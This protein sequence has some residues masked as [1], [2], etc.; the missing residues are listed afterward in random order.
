MLKNDRLG[1]RTWRLLSLLACATA[2]FAGC[3]GPESSDSSEPTTVSQSHGVVSDGLVISQVYGGGGN[4]VDGGS[5]SYAQDFVELFNRS[6]APIP[7]DGLS[8]QY[9]SV[10]GLLGSVNTNIVALPNK[11]VPAGGYFLVALDGPD[12]G[13]GA[14]ALPT[15]DAT[16]LA[17]LS[18]SSGKVALARTTTA[19]RCGG[20]ADGGTVPCDAEKIVDL[21]GY[22]TANYAEGN[23]VSGTPGALNAVRRRDAGCTETDSNA[24]DFE[25]VSPTPRNAATTVNV[26]A[27]DGGAPDAEVDSGPALDAAPEDGGA[28]DGGGGTPD[29][30]GPADAGPA[31]D[32]G[33]DAGSPDDSGIDAG[34]EDAATDGGPS[35]AST[36]GGSPGDGTGLVISK[37]FA[38][39]GNTNAAFGRDFIELFNR[40][41]APVSLAGLSVQYASYN[42]TFGTSSFAPPI[43]L[44]S[45][46]TI[47][48]G[49]YFLVGLGG[50][51]AGTG[52]ALPTPDVVGIA[53]LGGTR[54]KL[55]IARVTEPLGCG[56]TPCPATNV[57]DKV[58]WG[59]NTVTD[60][61]GASRAPAPA[62]GDNS[63]A[64]VRK[65]NGCID[66]NNNDAD[67]VTEKPAATPRNSASPPTTC[68]SA[69]TDAG[70]DSGTGRPDAGKSDAGSGNPFDSGTPPRNDGGSG[71]GAVDVDSG[72]S[73][74]TP[75]SSTPMNKG[76]AFAT[77]AALGL[78]ITARRRRAS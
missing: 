57:I 62:S 22:G 30:A 5:A 4:A 40:S 49:G 10:N 25:L 74:S 20:T 65:G 72:C 9:G 34:S 52:S 44:P 76:L 24:D 60:W 15:P 38:G 8:I 78:A 14:P 18:G 64:V 70:T 1:T 56:E 33:T 42:G 50:G 59:D 16:G 67:F 13:G 75:G 71:N 35:D 39:G 31:D 11:S 45:N 43:V 53:N 55:A 32:G 47:P 19:L 51:D 77:V 61:E 36:D 66:T 73:C 12:G 26:C 23:P 2:P 41:D 21:V 46:V 29:D 48:K 37:L 6:A 68:S 69:P 54:G 7:L 58:G 28:A 3:S 63:T 17:A 27:T